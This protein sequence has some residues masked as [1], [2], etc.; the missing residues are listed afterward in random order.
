MAR[1]TGPRWGRIAGLGLCAFVIGSLAGWIFGGADD[2]TVSTADPTT[3]TLRADGGTDAPPSTGATS[4]T[5]D[6]A[7]P[8]RDQIGAGQPVTFVFGGDIH[9]DGPLATTLANAPDSI[10]AGLQPTL[11]DADVAVVNLETAIGTGGTKAAKEFNFRASPAAFGALTS[12]G[13]DVIGMANNHALDY[14]QDGLTETLAAVA[15]TKAPVIGVGVNEAAALAPWTSTVNGQRISV[16]AATSVLDGNLIDSWTATEDHP[17][18]ASAKRVDQLV[19][20]VEAARNVSDTVVVFLHWGTETKFCANQNQLD[21]A[22]RLIIAGADLVIGSH[23][24]RVLAGGYLGSAYVDYGLGNLVFKAG[25]GDGRD[26]GLLRV[27]VTGRRVDDAEWLPGRI[28]GN[29]LPTLL[30]GADRDAELATWNSR[31]ACSELA[32]A[33][34]S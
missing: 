32:D 29:Y 27:T 20:A 22:P 9:F 5:V 19:A 30:D 13:V 17:G 3:T 12:A 4:T 1:R 7:A 31:R 11:S 26:T 21:L 14:G 23:A 18:V 15:E 25:S 10:L 33:P 34:D 28:G 24:H 16:I 6:P 8:V 2:A